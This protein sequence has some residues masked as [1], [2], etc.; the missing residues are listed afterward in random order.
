LK[1][2]IQIDP[3]LT[4][5]VLKLANSAYYSPGRKIS[6]IQEAIIRLGFDTVKEL[7]LSQK[8]CEIF[9]SDVT[10]CGY[11]RS[12]LWKHSLAV[13][14]LSKMIYRREFGQR[15]EI[16][17]AT[18][19]L[20]DI[21][22]IT[23]DQFQQEDFRLALSK[24]K[25]GEINMIQAE[26]EFFSFNH[27]EVGKAICDDWQISEDLT[28]AI[29]N[30]H[31]PSGVY[32]QHARMTNTLYI[33]DQYCQKNEIGYG[34]SQFEDTESFHRSLKRLGLEHRAL[35]ILLEDIRAEI[36]KMEE[37]GFLS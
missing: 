19:I 7:A 26:R 6:D 35:E 17:Y 21:G 11:S 27:T 24:S 9:K 30:H 5:R 25:N 36:S 4:A 33:A 1:K 22:L 15:G 18:G 32:K 10:F 28:I 20:H 8:V 3:P 13:A 29:G 16:I 23:E 2:I 34:D 14:L 31:D 12:A 37:Q